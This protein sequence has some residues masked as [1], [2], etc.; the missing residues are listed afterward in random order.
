LHCRERR[1]PDGWLAASYDIPR[2]AL[3]RPALETPPTDE[4]EVEIGRFKAKVGKPTMV[5]EL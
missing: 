4:R 3:E 2:Y 1:I 5:S